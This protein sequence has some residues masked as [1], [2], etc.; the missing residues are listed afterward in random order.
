MWCRPKTGIRH[1]STWRMV[2][3]MKSKYIPWTK[4]AWRACLLALR[5]FC[6]IPRFINCETTQTS[7]NIMG[8]CWPAQ[9]LWSSRSRLLQWVPESL[10]LP[11]LASTAFVDTA[12]QHAMLGVHQSWS[13]VSSSC[14]QPAAF[15]LLLT[16]EFVAPSNKAGTSI[17]SLQ[18]HSNSVS[19]A[20][21][22]HT[23]HFSD[24]YCQVLA[25]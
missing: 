18:H 19:A 25:H 4:E 6:P 9:T 2:Q 8:L 12:A 3:H 5:A 20:V 17:L 10:M 23:L 1:Y 7:T 16:P 21:N 14:I 13:Y 15:K 11:H 24:W 22:H